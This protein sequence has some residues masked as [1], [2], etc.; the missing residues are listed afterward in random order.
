MFI[1]QRL[2]CFNM[3]INPELHADN[4]AVCALCCCFPL[5]ALGHSSTAL[6]SP[7]KK[8]TW[9][10]PPA[11]HRESRNEGRRSGEGGGLGFLPWPE[12]LI[13]LSLLDSPLS[14]PV[15]VCWLLV[16]FSVC[17]CVGLPAEKTL[18][19]SWLCRPVIVWDTSVLKQKHFYCPFL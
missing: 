17:I 9:V 16:F 13:C 5:F 18:K 4:K 8:N 15:W 3:S 11:G 2:C 14:P 19:G 1:P 12:G 6:P 7:R 10:C